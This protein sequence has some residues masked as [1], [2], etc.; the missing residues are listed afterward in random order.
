[1]PK[2]LSLTP[3]LKPLGPRVAAPS[4]QDAE[5]ERFKERDRNVG[6]R[7]WCKTARWQKLRW[8]VLARD[9]FT[10]Q[11]PGCGHIEADT[12]QLVADHKHPHRGDEALFW[13]AANL[14][15]LCKPC[16]DTLKQKEEWARPGWPA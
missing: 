13:D 12:S 5:A 10:C 14:Q 4:R 7:K 15:C 2:L 1:M 16:H 6:W 9:L 3:R 8:S 11:M